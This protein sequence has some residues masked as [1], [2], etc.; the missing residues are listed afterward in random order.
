VDDYEQRG[1]FVGG[2]GHANGRR[3]FKRTTREY[4]DA[5]V[6]IGPTEV[7]RGLYVTRDFLAGEEILVFHGR[8]I[9]FTATLAKG[10]R[11]CDAF[12]IGPDLYLDL[13]PPG[14]YINHSC[15]PNTGV[16]DDV[17][18]VA[19]RDLR[20][21]EEIR[22]DYS[23]TMDED[24]WTLECLCGAPSC[25]GVIR[26]FR[27]LPKRTKKFLLRHNVVPAY[28][29]ASELAGGRLTARDLRGSPAA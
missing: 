3:R 10:D 20:E 14:V 9:D 24:H 7:G 23:T 4:G 13:V 22:Y 17:R 18:L 28:V 12:Q 6:L 16:R 21:G 5:N 27:W 25:R 11:E 19:L 8:R 26:D 1:P 2:N 15:E 29:I